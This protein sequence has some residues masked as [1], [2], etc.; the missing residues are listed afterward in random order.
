M[1]ARRRAA[2]INNFMYNRLGNEALV[3]N[4]DIRTRAHDAPLFKVVVP[5]VEA[6][7][8]SVVYAGALQW[9]NLKKETHCINSFEAFKSNQKKQLNKL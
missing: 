2:H 8:R 9:N 1:L 4:R 5:K 7:K 3:D 6:Y